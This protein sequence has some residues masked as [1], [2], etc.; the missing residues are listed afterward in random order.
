M[1]RG[2]C[3]GW[4]FNNLEADEKGMKPMPIAGSAVN[5]A[6]VV[7]WWGSLGTVAKAA[8]VA[9]PSLLVIA[10]ASVGI[11]AATGAFAGE[12]AVSEITLR[13]L[14]YG[15]TNT[16][17]SPDYSMVL[18]ASGSTFHITPSW[19]GTLYIKDA[20]G[21]GS[22]GCVTD[23]ASYSANWPPV[24]SNSSTVPAL[25]DGVTA[26]PTM[27]LGPDGYYYL[28]INGCIAYY[29][30]SNTATAWWQGISAVWPIVETDGT[31]QAA[32]PVCS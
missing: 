18:A 30:S 9:I 2:L 10:G 13:A 7:G 17:Q 6:A 25:P 1:A 16:A 32:A 11:A 29:Y 28:R 22:G 8:V 3:T 19:E 27:W 15:C 12:E 21:A 23:Y 31:T 14:T 24:T 5:N 26:T 20:D 4:T